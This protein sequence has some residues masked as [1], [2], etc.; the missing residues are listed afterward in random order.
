LDGSDPEIWRRFRLTG[1][2]TLFDLHNVI[3]IV[4]GWT[5]SHLHDFEIKGKRY[6]HRSQD[7]DFYD[8]PPIDEENVLVGK[9]VKQR[10]QK[11]LYVYDMGDDWQHTLVVEEIAESPPG[12]P[13]PICLAGERE[14]PPDDCGGIWGYYE[15]LKAV[16]DPQHEEH[17]SYREWLQAG[18][19]PDHFGLRGVNNTLERFDEYRSG[20]DEY[21]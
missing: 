9:V 5:D 21:E 17:E 10:G 16:Q 11:F 12:L 4:M 18:F 20:W 8:E 7:D 14:C 1:E 15:M 19:D 13:H 6:S 2:M 3:Q